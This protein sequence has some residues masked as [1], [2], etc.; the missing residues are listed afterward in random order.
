MAS[1]PKKL[2]ATVKKEGISVVCELYGCFKCSKT[3]FH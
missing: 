1:E 2:F 3:S